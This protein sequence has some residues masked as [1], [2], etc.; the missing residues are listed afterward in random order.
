M[1][2]SFQHKDID[3]GGT[4][5]CE[6]CIREAAETGFD[7]RAAMPV[8]TKDK[9]AQPERDQWLAFRR[10]STTKLYREISEEIR[11]RIRNATSA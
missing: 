1:P 8:L 9:N 7:L 10:N 5:F 11:R 4:C 2:V 6:Y 3:E